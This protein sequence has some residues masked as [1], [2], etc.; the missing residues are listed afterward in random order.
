MS[1]PFLSYAPFPPVG[2]VRD[3]PVTVSASSVRSA[4]GDGDG[5]KRK[6]MGPY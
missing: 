6:G 1:T 5:P 4:V 3:L 2:R